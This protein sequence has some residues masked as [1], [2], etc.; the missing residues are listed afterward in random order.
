MSAVT[1]APE[2]GSK[3]AMVKTTG[4]AGAIY[5]TLSETVQ[6]ANSSHGSPHTPAFGPVT[7]SQPL[8]GFAK[9]RYPANQ[10]SKKI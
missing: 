7:D 9:A 4:G 1:P 8:P 10:N 6:V 5:R 2:E 3:P